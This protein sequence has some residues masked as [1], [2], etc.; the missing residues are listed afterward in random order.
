M[1]PVHLANMADLEHEMRSMLRRTRF[2]GVDFDA[3]EA[4]VLLGPR[5]LQ[6]FRQFVPGYAIV[7]EGFRWHEGALAPIASGS[8]LP[9]VEVDRVALLERWRAFFLSLDCKGLAV[10]CSGG[11]DS[12]LIGVVLGE[13]GIPYVM[14]GLS[15]ERYEFRT[16]RRIQGWFVGKCRAVELIDFDSCLPM[17]GLADVPAHALPSIP[18]LSF[19]SERRM[20]IA[21]RSLGADVMISGSGGDVILAEPPPATPGEYQVHMFGDWWVRQH[22]LGSEGVRIAYPFADP[23]IVGTFWR[24]RAGAPMDPKKR[25]ARSLLAEL[26]PPMLA[27]YSYKSD[28]WG[29][30]TSG[31]LKNLEP[32][33][34]VHS[35]AHRLTGHPFFRSS[36]L[37]DLL[38]RDIHL[39]DQELHQRIEA[40]AALAVWVRGLLGSASGGPEGTR[41]LG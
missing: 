13:L 23:G 26:L 27:H 38:R 12:S 37:E 19:A 32:L 29:V 14:I 20:A 4:N 22:V 39:P 34:D 10:Q 2:A 3:F 9:P 1:K 33:R 7:P 25:W 11:L 36:R 16:E 17:S 21:A 5:R 35:D 31:L 30:H 8:P 15:T 28:F 40:R 6:E 18:S 24:L 41:E